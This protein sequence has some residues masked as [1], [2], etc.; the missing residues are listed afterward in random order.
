[1]TH[2]VDLS[3]GTASAR[4]LAPSR[5]PDRG[6]R[7]QRHRAGGRLLGKCWR[8]DAGHSAGPTAPWRVSGPWAA[9][10]AGPSRST[11]RLRLW[12]RSRADRAIPTSAG[13]PIAHAFLRKNGQMTDLGTLGGAN[14]AA[15]D[16]N[17]AGQIVG[18]SET[19][20]PHYRTPSCGGN[21][22][23]RGSAPAT[24]QAL[25]ALPTPSTP[26]GRW[27]AKKITVPSG[28]PTALCTVWA[29]WVPDAAPPP[30]S[31]RDVSQTLVDTPVGQRGFVFTGGQVTLL[32]LLPGG[33]N[34]DS[35]GY[36]WRGSHRWVHDPVRF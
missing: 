8:Q 33:T 23:M 12:E 18:R 3:G 5:P 16:I 28:T 9:E 34:N 30:I 25:P 26:M 15:L 11:T 32:P 36:Q 31:E 35:N 22:F 20:D 1:M 29:H 7:H 21:G 2:T 24:G 14:S 27:S 6:E 4:I 19:K 13:V 10:R 17:D